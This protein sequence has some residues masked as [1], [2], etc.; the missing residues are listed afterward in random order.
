MDKQLLWGIVTISFLKSRPS[1]CESPISGGG[2]AGLPE[3]EKEERELAEETRWRGL[4]NE[5]RA[6]LRKLGVEPQS[7]RK[8]TKKV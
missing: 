6:R 4:N 7:S 8:C 3:L 1:Q 2:G 5:Q